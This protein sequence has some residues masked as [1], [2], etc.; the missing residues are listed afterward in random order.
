VSMS[1]LITP[2]LDTSKKSAAW[3][4]GAEIFFNTQVHG[5]PAS[6][7]IRIPARKSSLP[8][9]VSALYRGSFC[10]CERERGLSWCC[11]STVSFRPCTRVSCALSGFGETETVASFPDFWVCCTLHITLLVACRGSS[12]PRTWTW[13][14]H[15][16]KCSRHTRS[17]CP[18]PAPDF[19]FL[20]EYEGP[21]RTQPGG[22][23]RQPCRVSTC[24]DRHF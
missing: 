14:L 5:H 24:T 17:V 11:I 7:T 10:Y 6:P 16:G 4:A 9:R 1:G 13:E 19:Q 18:C 20:I 12:R 3:R 23:R 8:A 22:R 21:G 15:A 2:T